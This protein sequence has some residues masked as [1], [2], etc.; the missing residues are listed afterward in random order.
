MGRLASLAPASLN[1]EQRALFEAITTGQRSRGRSPEDF[2][3]PDG[4]L[5]GPFN[6]WLYAAK[7]G[8]PAQRLG[9][10]IRYE[11]DLPPKLRELAILTVAAYWRADYEWWAHSRIGRDA[12]LAEET[13]A[14]VKKGKI[15]HAAGSDERTVHRFA[16]EL[17]DEKRLRDDTYRE[18]AA[19]LGDQGAVE[20]VSLLGYYSLVSMTLKAFEVAMPAGERSPFAD[21]R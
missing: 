8:Y 12:G 18:A 5:R 21:D 3:L 17:M 20:L 11:T 10:A 19:L 4:G 6:P 1:P 13:I 16:R 14:A 15:P 9:E 7:I 2:L